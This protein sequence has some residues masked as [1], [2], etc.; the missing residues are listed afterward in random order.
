MLCFFQI[1]QTTSHVMC[2]QHY[3]KNSETRQD[4]ALRIAKIPSRRFRRDGVDDDTRTNFDA[5][6]NTAT[7]ANLEVQMLVFIVH[8]LMKIEIIG[9]AETSDF[10]EDPLQ[11]ARE[12]ESLLFVHECD[13]IDVPPREHPDFVVVF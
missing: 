12:R 11:V 2:G 13:V 1:V 4:G 7:G 6:P 10:L 9:Q 8:H 3:I 5:S